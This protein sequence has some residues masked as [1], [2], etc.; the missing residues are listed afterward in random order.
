MNNHPQGV[1]RNS[2]VR[3][4]TLNN[5]A[6][7]ALVSSADNIGITIIP[8]RYHNDAENLH[9]DPDEGKVCNSQNTLY[10]PWTSVEMVIV[11]GGNA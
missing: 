1:Q 3:L 6:Y 9:L 4:Y 2:N 5:T 8:I 11:L 7:D 10:F